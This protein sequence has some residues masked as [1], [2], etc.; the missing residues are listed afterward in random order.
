MNVKLKVT[1]LLALTLALSHLSV[2][3]GVFEGRVTA[4]QTRGS[5]VQTYSYTISTN[6]LRIERGETDWPHAKNLIALDTGAVTLLFPHNRS[7]IRQPAATENAAPVGIPAM[8][9]PAAPPPMNFGPTNL[10][11]MPTPPPMP[12]MPNGMAA[13][14]APPA[15]MPPGMP[16]MPPMPV[17]TG[18]GL[19]VMPMMPLPGEALELRATGEKTNLLGYACEKFEIKQRGEIM[20]IWAT[21]QLIPFRSWQQNQRPRVSPPMIEEKWG[22]LVR[23]RKLFPLLAVLK[24]EG[25]GERLRFEV[26]TITPQ[27]IEDKD[28]TL[29]QPPADYHELEPLPF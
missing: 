25:G 17:G 21:D 4:S 1:K 7:F 8:S 6:R 26:K 2:H 5:E 12:A 13:P 23:A 16:A 20:E 11:G 15:S 24:F 29:F 18:G 3:A 28:G 27:K 19:P 22:D 10:P 14:P 9:V